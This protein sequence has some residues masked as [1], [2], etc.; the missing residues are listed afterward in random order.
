MISF[1]MNPKMSQADHR[2]AVEWPSRKSTTALCRDGHVGKPWSRK[3]RKGSATDDLSLQYSVGKAWTII[4]LYIYIPFQSI[5][6]P[7]EYIYIYYI[8]ILYILYIYIFIIYSN[9]LLMDWNGIFSL[10]FKGGSWDLRILVG[11]LEHGFY[12]SIYWE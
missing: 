9:G 2:I 8:Y 3:Y 7:L 1:L 11:A 10:D 5:K 6:S 12:F 4:C